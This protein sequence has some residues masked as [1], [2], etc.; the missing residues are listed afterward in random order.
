MTGDGQ[1]REPPAR[2]CEIACSRWSRC[3]AGASAMAS[4]WESATIADVFYELVE[5]AQIGVVDVELEL[6]HE[7]RG[8]VAV[9]S[10]ADRVVV[11]SSHSAWPRLLRHTAFERRTVETPVTT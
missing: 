7:L 8:P 9:G 4:A 1:G 5:S 11:V 2:R 6:D 10:G 3:G